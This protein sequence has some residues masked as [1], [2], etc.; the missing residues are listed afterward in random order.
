MRFVAGM[1]RKFWNRNVI[2]AGLASG[3][4]EP[5]ES[6]SIHFVQSSIA[7]LVAYF[8]DKRFNQVDIDTYNE[9]VQFEYVRARDFIVLHYIATER[10][11][12]PFWQRCREIPLPDTLKH[13]MDL[14]RSAGRIHREHEELFTEQSWVQVLVGQ[15]VMPESYHP[16]VDALSLDEIRAMV[17][18]VKGVLERSADYMPDH[19][20]FIEK[21]CK[22]ESMG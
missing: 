3:F 14:F 10:T 20:E 22:A 9:Q 19:R 6:T 2:A 1:R 17:E 11:D 18:G 16:M 5:L 21:Y 13:K 15:N 7:K 8:P 4:M 12:S